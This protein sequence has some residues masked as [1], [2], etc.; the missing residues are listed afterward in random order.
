MYDTVKPYDTKLSKFISI[1][2]NKL[3]LTF[4][5][6][7]SGGTCLQT[8]HLGA[9]GTIILAEIVRWRPTCYVRLCIE[10]KKKKLNKT[11]PM[12]CAIMCR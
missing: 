6:A 4:F 10:K 9:R 2:K 5:S 11:K 12:C 8:Q 3:T 1:I 7:S